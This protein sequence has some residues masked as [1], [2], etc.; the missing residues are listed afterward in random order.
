MNLPA[1]W[2]VRILIRLIRGLHGASAQDRPDE[3]LVHW[4]QMRKAH[5]FK[6]QAKRMPA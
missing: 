1:G 3:E 6:E 2:T 5:K 4:T